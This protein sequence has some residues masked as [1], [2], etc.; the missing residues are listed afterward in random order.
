MDAWTLP[1][2]FVLAFLSFLMLMEG[3]YPTVRSDDRERARRTKERLREFSRSL[4]PIQPREDDA[5]IVRIAPRRRG[6]LDRL[7]ALLLR[8]GTAQTARRFLITSLGAALAGFLGTYALTTSALRAAP[9]VVLGAAPLLLVR[10]RAAKRMQTFADQLPEG[11]ELLTRTLRAGHALSAGFSLV[12]EETPDPLGTEFSL[13]AEEL[14]FGLELREALENL[15]ARVANPD[16]PYFTTAVLIQRQTGGNLAELLEKL[17]SML[18]ERIQFSGRV[19]AMTAQGRGAATFLALW[20]PG[21]V[22]LLM[23][24]APTFLDPMFNTPLGLVLLT[25]AFAIDIVAY[26]LARRIADVQA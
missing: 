16:L 25:A 15:N 24:V 23:V 14:R 2:V 6:A 17:G 19:R 21:M 26:L 4:Q 10:R 20:M 11:L 12:G 18:R 13:V 8:A 7:Q 22:A 3:L 9:A 5:T 1:L